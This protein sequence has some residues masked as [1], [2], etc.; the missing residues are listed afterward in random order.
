MLVQ[1]ARLSAFAILGVI[2]V[3]VGGCQTNVSQRYANEAGTWTGDA[4]QDISALID[5]YTKALLDKDVARLDQ[6]WADDLSFVNPRGELLSKENRMDNVKSGATA[7]KSIQLLDKRIRTYGQ[8]AVAVCKVATEAQYSGEE[9][10]GTYSATTVWVRT[11]P[12]WRM[13]AVQMTRI[14]A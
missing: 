8:T 6:I 5:Q 7:F 9:A 14:G 3:N 12:T 11:G 2:L 13:V 10:S 4:S 1:L